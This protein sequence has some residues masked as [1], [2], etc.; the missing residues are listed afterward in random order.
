MSKPELIDLRKTSAQYDLNGK[1]SK[2]VWIVKP[3]GTPYSVLIAIISL[4]MSRGRGIRVF[5]DLNNLL[6]YT[7]VENH[8]ESQWIVQK[9]M[10]NPLLIGN[11]KFDIRQW[12]LVTSWNP[13]TIWFY[14]DCYLRFCVEEFSLEDLV[15]LKM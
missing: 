6:Q 12:V 8:K 7:D 15:R 1:K 10:E 4:G 11:R 5:D 13:I 9:Y 3:A 14:N 2:N